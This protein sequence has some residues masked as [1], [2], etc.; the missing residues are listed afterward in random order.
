MN[1][2]IFCQYD[3]DLYFIDFLSIRQINKYMLLSKS[4]LSMFQNS[5]YYKELQSYK[6]K[7]TYL[8]TSSICEGGY[9]NLLKLYYKDAK[10]I[11]YDNILYYAIKYGQ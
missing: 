5:C 7:H 8:N 2:T 4:S 3:L 1:L 6:L 9:L 11:N 10:F